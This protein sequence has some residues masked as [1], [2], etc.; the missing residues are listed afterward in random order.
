MSHFFFVHSVWPQP[1]NR[2]QEQ[3]KALGPSYPPASHL[4][5]I[6]QWPD[7][8]WLAQTRVSSDTHANSTSGPTIA[9]PVRGSLAEGSR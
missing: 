6:P 4:A 9:G 7:N 3:E 8:E 2:L 1:R 5:N